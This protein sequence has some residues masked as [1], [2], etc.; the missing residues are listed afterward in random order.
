[1]HTFTWLIWLLAAGCAI[2]LAPNPLYLILAL[3][4]AWQVFQACR[5]DSPL[6]RSFGLFLRFGAVICAGYVLFSVVTVGGARGALVVLELP[7]LRL[8]DWLGGVVLGGP[9]TVEALAYG[10]TRGLVIWALMAVFGAFNA[11]VDHYRLLRLSPRSLYHAGLA[12]TIATAFVPS[13]IRAISEIAAAQRARGH[14]FGKPSSWLALVA[15]LL[16]GSLEKSLQLAEALDARGY[17]RT[18]STPQS[19][20]A[21]QLLTLSGLLALAGGLFGWF[22]YGPEAL[23]PAGGLLVGG[24]ALAGLGMWLMGRAVSRSSYRRERWRM[25][26]SLVTVAAL[27]SLAVLLV[28]RVGGASDMVYYP[29]PQ[30]TA[31]GFDLRA[32]FA[33]LLLAAPAVLRAPAR[34]DRPHRP[35]A[36][37]APQ[38][39]TEPHEHKEPYFTPNEA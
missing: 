3:L 35:V 2:G 6:A 28:L 37:R 27:L 31:P 8:P 5:D 38:G 23:W 11:L 17:G 10:L 36:R 29:F 19:R 20:L 4:A 33:F 24:V 22:Y 34:P 14:R 30:L 13:L 32:G 1:M 39:R 15:P 12:I 9:I 18:V 26:D 7:A 16:A 25:R 21:P